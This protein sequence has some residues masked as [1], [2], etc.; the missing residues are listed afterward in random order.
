VRREIVNMEKTI[1][2]ETTT[3]VKEIPAVPIEKDVVVVESTKTVVSDVVVVPAPP[4]RP[5]NRVVVITPTP[6]PLMP[7]AAPAVVVTTA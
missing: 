7:P 5:A 6:D 2:E 3:V 4:V 1:V